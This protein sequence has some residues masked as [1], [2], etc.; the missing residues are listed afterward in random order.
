MK[1][2]ITAILLL[3]IWVS[4]TNYEQ[5]GIGLTEAVMAK[6]DTSKP[7]V[8]TTFQGTTLPPIFEAAFV[9]GT[10]VV[11][12]EMTYIFYKYDVGT[13]KIESGKIIASDPIVMRDASAFTE[14]FPI[15]SFPVHL[16]LAK[17][18]KDERVAFSRIVFSDIPVVHWE[19]A[20]K[21]GEKPIPI[22]D[23]NIYCY[24]VDAGIGLFI[25]SVANYYF[26]QKK[27]S[28]WE[29]VFTGTDK[30][31]RRG[32]MHAFEGHNLATFTTGYGDGCYATYIGFDKEGHACQLLTDFGLVAWWRL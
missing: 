25:D 3:V 16:A 14:H 10:K 29:E 22:K 2:T 1:S 30:T 31:M 18:D 5:P 9:P 17:T 24:G 15:G 12:G 4:C 19:Y 26:N 21:E 6:P 20:L 27:F 11:Q 28:E 32:Y 13:I 23:T 7:M 8:T